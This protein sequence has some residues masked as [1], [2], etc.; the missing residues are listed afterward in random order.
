M[1]L[2]SHTVWQNANLSDVLMDRAVMNE[3]N[4]RNAN[5]QRT[6]FT[7]SVCWRP[8]HAPALQCPTCPCMFCQQMLLVLTPAGHFFWTRGHLLSWHAS[9]AISCGPA[10]TMHWLCHLSPF[11]RIKHHMLRHGQC[12]CRSDLGGADING[13]DFTNALLDKTQ[14]I[15]RRMHP[16]KPQS[17]CVRGRYCVKVSR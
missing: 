12:A 4:L 1:A 2:I 10:R 6:I 16:S 3:A 11:L 9:V 15:V 8:P 5:L 14:Q 17:H 7:R 13:L